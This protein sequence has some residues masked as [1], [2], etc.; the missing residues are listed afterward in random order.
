M[1]KL[2]RSFENPIL[3][4]DSR[5]KWEAQACFNPSVWK[6]PTG[7]IMVYRALS[8]K[9]PYFHDEM[10]VSTIGYAESPDPIHFVNRRQLITPQYDWEKYGCEDPRITKIGEA[11]YIFYT[12]LGGFPFGPDNIKVAVAV[13]RDLKSIDEKHLV[14]PF[15]AKGACLLPEKING[16]YAVILTVN[17]DKPPVPSLIGIAYFDSIEDIWNQDIWNKWYSELNSHKIDLLRDTSHQVEVGAV[18]LKTKFG[19]L[20]IHSYTRDYFS[21]DKKFGIEAVLLELGNPQNIVARTKESMLS[22]KEQ[23]E[24]FG[25]V[26]YTIFPSGAVISDTD[27]YVYYGAADTVSAVAS[28]NLDALINDMI[29]SSKS[30]EQIESEQVHLERFKGNPIISPIKDHDWESEYTLNAAAIYLEGKVYILYR[31]QGKSGVSTIGLAISSD[32]LNIDERL[33]KPVYKPR[34]DAEKDGCED[35]RITRMGNTLYLFYTAFKDGM[36][37][38]AMSTISVSDFLDRNWKWSSP[39]IISPTEL[40]DKNACVLPEKIDGKYVIFHRTNHRIWIAEE[41]NLDFSD[42]RWI[43]GNILFEPNDGW[44]SEKV[45]IAAP[46]IKTTDGWLLIFHGISKA[47]WKYRLGA[48]LLDLKYPLT[49]KALL[50]YP[51]LEPTAPYEDSGLRPGTVFSCG[52]VVI[53]DTLYVYYGAGDTTVAVATVGLEKLLTALKNSPIK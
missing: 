5:N 40:N 46:P 4:P 41:E 28:V 42:G 14:T 47:D 18:P 31:A 52:A 43:Q 39:V 22:P 23:Y 10:N 15:N 16:K 19:W 44:Y 20:L 6:D 35:A 26:P 21:M 1:L 2:I 34:I 32:G 9:I 51:I 8:P 38:I 45:G 11:Y 17:T 50:D 24:L 25:E 3:S 36:T 37:H 49:I 13:T 53:K 29:T 30:V 7:F 33:D 12:A 48:M 27:L